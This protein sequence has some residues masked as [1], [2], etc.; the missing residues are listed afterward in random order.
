MEVTAKSGRTEVSITPLPQISSR[1][2]STGRSL[3]LLMVDDS[4]ADAELLLNAVRHDGYQ[5]THALVHTSAGMQ[6]ALK[7]RQ[8][9]VI[10]SDHSMPQFSASAALTLAK[11]LCP[12]VPFIIVSGEI[13]VNLA[14][15]LMKGGAQ[16]YIQK[17]EM[18]R[19]VPAIER[20]LRE[21][22]IRREREQTQQALQVSEIRYRR[23][24]E[25]AQDGILILDANTG[26][27]TDVNP[28]LMEMLG[29]SKEELL[30]KKLWEIGAFKEVEASKFAFGELQS[31]G[32]VRYED[33][34]LE[35]N[36][37]KSIEVEF[38]SNV[39]LVDQTRVAQCNIRDITAR[40]LADAEIR[41]LNSELEQRVRE[42][43]AQLEDLNQELEA[44]SY[45]VSHDLRAPLRR[46]AGFAEALREDAADK[47]SAD[48]LRLIQNIRAS[49][50]RMNAL[51][52]ALLQLARLS[53]GGIKPHFV[54][55][56]ALVH[57]IAEELRQT[58]PSR[59]V[60]FSVA[61]NITCVGDEQLLRIM[62]ENLLSNAWKFTIHRST[63]RIEFG[64][65]RQADGHVVYFVRDNGAGFEMAYADRLFGAFKRLHS[66]KEFPGLGIGLATVQRIVHRHGGQIWAESAVNEGAT[67]YFTLAQTTSSS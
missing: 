57:G 36:R 63:S 55:L 28:Y 33:L 20:A 30:G 3:R 40:K 49:V 43:T 64:A 9:D 44:F 23:L 24:F 52:D 54:N 53:S 38:V 4:E 46:I 32:Y 58:Q 15:A 62:L 56:S 37:G 5:I 21:V 47:L 65:A 34:P 7:R 8:W 22:E 42:R 41:K 6:E 48:N 11:E 51:I 16:D 61:D 50:D 10:T 39:Y 59:Q 67:F 60:S 66:E 19:L 17:R 12:A 45:S 25:T 18:A 1:E 29:Y 2:K 27:I 14:V 26:Q 35:S 31:K 13:D